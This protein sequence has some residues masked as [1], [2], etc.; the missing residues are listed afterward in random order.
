[1][2]DDLDSG[3]VVQ[4]QVR[5]L[6]PM[7]SEMGVAFRSRTPSPAA[8]KAVNPIEERAAQVNASSAREHL[9]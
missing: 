1:M 3:A 4:L 5:D 2:R 7:F 8:Q 9:R 6:P